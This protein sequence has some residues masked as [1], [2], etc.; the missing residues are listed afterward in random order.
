MNVLLC[1]DDAPTRLIIRNLL[2][3]YFKCTVAECANGA[4]ALEMLGHEEFAFMFLDLTMPVMD[5]VEAL[6]KIR[7]T[8]ATKDLPVIILSG[9]S[10][11]QKI[12]K[13]ARLGIS[14]YVLKPP[15][16][17][18]VVGKI[19]KVI[20]SL[21]PSGTRTASIALPVPSDADSKTKT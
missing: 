19:E 14:E 21:P 6:E 12:V 4:E 11:Q 20:R 8:P 16:T 3:G 5:G 1:D 18:T 9:E 7:Q 2:E 15:R 10:D 13:V 17:T